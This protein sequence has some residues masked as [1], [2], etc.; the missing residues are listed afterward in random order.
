VLYALDTNILIYVEG[1][2][3]PKKCET[4]RDLL[5][6]IEGE[7]LLIPVQVLGELYRVLNG[8][9]GVSAGE[10]RDVLAHWGDS[11]NV[12]GSELPDLLMAA[13]LSGRHGL[14]IWDALIMAVSLASGGRVLLTEDMQHGFV[15]GGLTLVDP[16]V[17][18]PHPLIAHL[19]ADNDDT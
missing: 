2:G 8:K 14:Q 19:Y 3:D 7:R 10:S 6:R 9:L 12:A 16:F 15:W 11:G 13:E 1:Y 18:E 4:A 17:R 5:A